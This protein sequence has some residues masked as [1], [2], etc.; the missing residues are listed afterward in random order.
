M[1]EPIPELKACGVLL[2]QGDPVQSFLLMRHADRW[3]LP[4][5]HLDGS[6]TE[7][8]CA[9]REMEEETGLSKNDIQ[10]DPEF[11]YMDRYY[12]KNKR[13][14]NKKK[15]KEL[16]IFL[17]RVD[18]KPKIEVTEHEGFEWFE[19]SPPHEIQWKTID[20]LLAQ[21]EKFLEPKQSS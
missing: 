13:T 7:I 10:I 1:T 18:S 20:P 6:E 3:D 14:R 17:A 11:R 21:V 5:G 15:L 4:K 12:V 2:L 8:E 9:L 19:W 16:V